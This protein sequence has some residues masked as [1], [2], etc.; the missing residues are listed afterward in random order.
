M[1]YLTYIIDNYA[2]LPSTMAFVHPHRD[3]FLSAWHTDA[4]L[5]SNV[6]ALNSLQISFAQQNGYVNLRCN[7]NPGGIEK[8]RNNK[9]VTAEVWQEM[10]N[11]TSTDKGGSHDAPPQVAAACCAQFAVSR[12]RVLERPLSDYQHFRQWI[13]DTEMTDYRSGRVFEYLWH[14]IF[15]MEAL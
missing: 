11:G 12:S 1:A 10:F 14:V 15:G 7:W 4:P 5:H 8:H 3:G 2:A 9:F 6:N 13:I